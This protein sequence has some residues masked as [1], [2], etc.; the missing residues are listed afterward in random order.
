MSV[1]I[2]DS[3]EPESWRRF[4]ALHPRASIFHTPEMVRVFEGTP[5]HRPLAL[6]A[7]D[8]VGDILALL[9][10]VRVRTLRWLP[11]RVA[12]RMLMYAEPL[13]LE[14]DRGM[15]ALRAL[16]EEH[17]RR[18][19]G[20]ALF[21]E[22]RPLTGAAFEKE[23]LTSSGYVQEPYLNYLID[24]STPPEAM[25]ARMNS[26]GRRDVRRGLRQNLPVEDITTREDMLCLYS[27]LEETYAHARVPLAPCELFLRAFDI[28]GP[29][30][31]IKAFLVRHQGAP[32]AGN[33]VL[34][35]KDSV[36]FW[37]AGLHRGTNLM[38]MEV[39]TF[40][41]LEWAHRN[42]YRTF[43]LGGAGRPDK[44]YG[45]RDFKAKLGGELVQF[46][47]YR[48]VYSPVGLALAER[49][50]EAS[51]A[52]WRGARLPSAKRTEL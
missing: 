7:V 24:T 51:R 11:G 35:F 47:R 19:R 16:V 29:L 37:F 20:A 33:V 15:E 49:A 22:V 26:H 13:C 6:A 8:S 32:L 42:G 3:P 36:F 12:A 21:A 44:P 9:V 23:P 50:Y 46:G 52:L 31:R 1:N 45:V 4:V 14:S 5:G 41:A 30:G 10:S 2:I 28:L 34:C 17:D 40:A 38:A 39:A 27:L 18:M 43:D 48:K 25:L